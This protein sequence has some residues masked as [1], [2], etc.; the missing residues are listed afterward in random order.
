MTKANEM[1]EEMYFNPNFGSR[2][3]EINKTN[4]ELVTELKDSAEA[5][6]WINWQVIGLAGGKKWLI[7]TPVKTQE[8]ACEVIYVDFKAKTVLK[9]AG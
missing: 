4:R 6:G 8:K 2:K 5:S 9:R 7:L 3:I 1:M